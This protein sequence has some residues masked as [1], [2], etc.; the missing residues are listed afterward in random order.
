MRLAILVLTATTIHGQRSDPLSDDVRRAYAEVRNNILRS[1]EKMPAENYDFRPAPR[2]RTFAQLMGHVA[3]E[4]YLFFCGPV[5]GEQKA[6]DVE[7]TKTTKAEL[8][9]ALKD[10]F[11]Y[12]DSA[13]D[14]ITD[15]SAKEIVNTGGNRS[16][17][18][19]LLW[20]NVVH[21]QSHYGNIVTYLRIKGIVPPSTEG[22]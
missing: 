21:D 1:A 16:M 8:L 2:V 18:L 7:R 14:A 3:Q 20:M 9:V 6:A 22:Q 4:Q 17:K 19:R 11:A 12:C 13:Y 5:K 15:A 10:S